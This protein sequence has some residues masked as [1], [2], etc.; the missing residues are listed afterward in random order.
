MFLSFLTISLRSHYLALTLTWHFETYYSFI[1]VEYYKKSAW[2]PTRNT[3][4]HN[5]KGHASRPKSN[6]MAERNLNG[7]IKQMKKI[8][9]EP[10]SATGWYNSILMIMHDGVDP[11]SVLRPPDAF[12]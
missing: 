12:R 4:K 11:A 1:Y 8:C 6:N 9:S 2:P 10:D 7:A 3:I 5:S